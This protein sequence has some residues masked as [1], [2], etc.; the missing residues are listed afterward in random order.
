MHAPLRQTFSPLM[1][2]PNLERIQNT[3]THAMDSLDHYGATGAMTICLMPDSDCHVRAGGMCAD[4]TGA[5]MAL[6][7]ATSA[8]RKMAEQDGA[9]ELTRILNEVAHLLAPAITIKENEEVH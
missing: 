4:L 9:A 3:L 8:L 1:E 2:K 5:M 7:A 6:Y